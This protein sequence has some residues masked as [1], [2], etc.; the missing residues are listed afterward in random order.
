MCAIA[1]HT[2]AGIQTRTPDHGLLLPIFR[3]VLLPQ[4][5]NPRNTFTAKLRGLPPR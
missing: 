2:S 3:V 5:I 4:L 1:G